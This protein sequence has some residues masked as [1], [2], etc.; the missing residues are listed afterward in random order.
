MWLG[1]EAEKFHSD[2]A[3]ESTRHQNLKYYYVTA[4]EMAQFVHQAE[5]GQREPDFDALPSAASLGESQ[6]V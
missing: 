6:A 3:R 1:P 5:A 4:W 2:L